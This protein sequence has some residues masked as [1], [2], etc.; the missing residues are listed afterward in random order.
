MSRNELQGKC[1]GIAVVV[2]CFVM[3][4][5][6]LM[7]QTSETGALIG[8][9]TDPSAAV[10][11]NATVTATDAATGLLYSDVHV[12]PSNRPGADDVETHRRCNEFLMSGRHDFRLR[13]EEDS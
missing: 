11:P 5:S 3:F 8:T 13:L 9:V 12:I 10:V 2:I 6:S 7:G 4:A 1:S